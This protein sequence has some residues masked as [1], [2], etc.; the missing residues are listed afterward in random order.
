MIYF[1]EILEKIFTNPWVVGI[2]GGTLSGLLVAWISRKLF[3]Q[4]ENKEYN[5]KVLSANQEVLY[6]LRPLISES[7]FPSV[8]VLNS[9][10][11]ATS[12]KYK[13]DQNSM[14]TPSQFFDELIKEV[15]DSNFIPHEKKS[16]YSSHLI[17]LKKETDSLAETKNKVTEID[18]QYKLHRN[19]HSAVFS[20]SMGLMVMMTTVFLT[21]SEFKSN[22]LLSS[23]FLN[24][25]LPIGA[26]LM[27][28]VLLYS[29]MSIKSKKGSDVLNDLLKELKNFLP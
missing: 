23:A 5:Q 8:A 3:S 15:M 12:R 17:N 6:S 19:E 27:V 4:K 29:A 1:L 21:L 11:S 9:L 22:L 28:S 16:E 26:A 18:Y 20:L 13:V 24:L 25:L 10:V 14:C 2:G 7:V